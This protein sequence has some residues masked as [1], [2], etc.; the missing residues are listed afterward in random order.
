MQ[1]ITNPDEKEKISDSSG[2]FFL[3]AFATEIVLWYPIECMQ[4]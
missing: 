3:S 2:L 1:K 4:G